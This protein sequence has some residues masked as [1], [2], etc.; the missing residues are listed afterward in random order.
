MHRKAP[1]DDAY[2]PGLS[3]DVEIE[4]FP[5][6]TLVDETAGKWPDRFAIDFRGSE[7]G[8]PALADAI[9][10][11]AQRFLNEVDAA[12]D[13]LQDNQVSGVVMGRC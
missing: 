6:H 4:T 9:D 7:I 12:A 2:P 8:Y 13:F 5:V 3:A 10:R 1:W 11:T